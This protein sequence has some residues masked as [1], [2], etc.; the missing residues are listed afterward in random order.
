[1]TDTNEMFR[2]N[3]TCDQLPA[4]QLHL[5][6][7]L[8][9]LHCGCCAGQR[10]AYVRT[11]SLFDVKLY[12]CAHHTQ[13]KSECLFKYVL[14]TV[15]IRDQ[16]KKTNEERKKELCILSMVLAR[17]RFRLKYKRTDFFFCILRHFTTPCSKLASSIACSANANRNCLCHFSELAFWVLGE[18][19]AFKESE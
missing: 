14:I 19:L 3:D 12:I 6:T 11:I 18:R 1:M 16:K 8:F 7:N 17:R 9:T 15:I 2:Q 13:C 5:Y 10:F 4:A